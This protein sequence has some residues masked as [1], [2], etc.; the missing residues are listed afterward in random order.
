MGPTPITIEHP[1]WS[2]TSSHNAKWVPDILLLTS[3]KPV[4]RDYNVLLGLLI[5]GLERGKVQPRPLVGIN[6]YFSYHTEKTEVTEEQ[7][8]SMG[9]MLVGTSE[10]S[11]QPSI[12]T[13]TTRL[14][15]QLI[16]CPGLNVFGRK[17]IPPG[18][19]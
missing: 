19:E 1:I 14:V 4:S 18:F 12:A 6:I 16:P 2:Y 11:N 9:R 3:T 7:L 10:K 13:S 17:Y 8:D 5:V 15:L